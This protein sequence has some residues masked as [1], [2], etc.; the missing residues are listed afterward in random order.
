MRRLLP[1]VAIAAWLAA[2]CGSTSIH[3]DRQTETK[4]SAEEHVVVLLSRY[5]REGVEVDEL[6]SIEGG[7]EAC[8]R[9]AAQTVNEGQAFL[10]PAD[11]RELVSRDAMAPAGSMSV[12]SLLRAL[13]DRNTAARL[14]RAQARFA[15]LLE[16][17]Y[18]TSQSKWG[19]GSSDAGFAVG[20]D[21]TQNSSMRATILDLKHA[22]IAGSITAHSSGP[23]GGGVGVFI[24]IPF[25][26]YFTSMAE[27]RAC[28]AIGTEL[29]RFL[30]G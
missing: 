21:W 7:L 27:S 26:I 5:R 28:G 12:D 17:A 8:V 24:I 22:R 1:S 29:A 19:F 18:T 30:S 14:V 6:G 10:Y 9:S 25:P 20:K 13:S 15:V 16:A 4:A 3:T 2:G 23:E 11:F